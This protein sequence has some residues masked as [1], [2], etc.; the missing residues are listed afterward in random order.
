MYIQL[1]Y[2]NEGRPK[3]KRNIEETR[4]ENFPKLMKG[5][6]PQNEDILKTS[7]RGKFNLTPV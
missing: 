2:Q 6:N 3:R 4:V 1:E 7:A 5:K